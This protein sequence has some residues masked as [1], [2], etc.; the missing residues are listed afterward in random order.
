MRAAVGYAEPMTPAEQIE[1]AC[2]MEAT[3]RK[4]GNVHPA[5]AFDD[6]CFDDFVK[7]AAASAPILAEAERLG[8]G[9]AVFEAV[10]ATREVC[11]GNVNLGICLLIAPMAAV[12]RHSSL[13]GGISQVL[14]ATTVADAEWVYRAIRLAQPGG[15]G[16][17]SEQD[18]ADAPTQSLLDVMKLAAHRDGVAREYAECYGPLQLA[19]Q[20]LTNSCQ[21]SASFSLA[22]EPPMPAWEAATILTH[23]AMIAERDTLIERKCGTEIA[24]EAAGRAAAVLKAGHLQ[25]T[26]GQRELQQFDRWLRADGHRRNPGTSADR[27]AACLFWA[28]REGYIQPPTKAEVLHHARQIAAASPFLQ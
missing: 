5:V 19:V 17:A 13:A 25:S 10:Q 6:L 26:T 23:I 4:P 22:S 9:R 18:V 12:P 27:I 11:A 20:T 16:S 14:Q 3:A 28:I 8:I 7:A 24:K 2:L 15:L 1:I 21:Q